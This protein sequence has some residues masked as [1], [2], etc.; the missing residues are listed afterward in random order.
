M[1]L[2]DSFLT[3][4]NASHYEFIC[5]I[6]FQI[7]QS[8]AIP[9]MQPIIIYNYFVW[10]FH[11]MG[12]LTKADYETQL[13]MIFHSNAVAID[14]KWINILCNDCATCFCAMVVI[15]NVSNADNIVVIRWKYHIVTNG[16]IKNC[17]L[18]FSILVN[19]AASSHHGT[20]ES[21]LHTLPK[22]IAGERRRNTKTARTTKWR[23]WRTNA[24][25]WWLK[26]LQMQRKSLANG[27]WATVFKYLPHLFERI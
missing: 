10:D 8:N 20:D 21:V 9:L 7:F 15:L 24:F 5:E 11:L 27:K 1:I 17:F 13:Q 19:F 2:E 18:F 4:E 25:R 6:P 23:W 16:L 12:R 14:W 22:I 3:V 26:R